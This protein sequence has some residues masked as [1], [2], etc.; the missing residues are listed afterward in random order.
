MAKNAVKQCDN[1]NKMVCSVTCS[2]TIAGLS[3]QNAAL[4][5]N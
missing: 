1:C 3:L 5:R 4:Q 2:P